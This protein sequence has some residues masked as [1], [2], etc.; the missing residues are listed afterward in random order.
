M[1]SKSFVLFENFEEI[2][3][4][5]VF[6]VISDDIVLD[7]I[8]FEENRSVGKDLVIDVFEKEFDLFIY[9]KYCVKNI[10]VKDIVKLNEDILS[11]FLIVFFFMKEY[12]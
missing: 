11:C 8:L 7:I 1:V 6:K 9:L 4:L 5:S 3:D 12:L 10:K 2:F